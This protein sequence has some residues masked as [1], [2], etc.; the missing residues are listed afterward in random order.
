MRGKVTWVED[1]HTT[2]T[3]APHTAGGQ[4]RAA[5]VTVTGVRDTALPAT[6]TRCDLM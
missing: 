3:P 1:N 2:C 6:H 5:R 4:G